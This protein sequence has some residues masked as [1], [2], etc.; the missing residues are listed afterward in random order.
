MRQQGQ[1]I[2]GFH[3]FTLFDAHPTKTPPRVLVHASTYKGKPLWGY[4][5]FDNHA[6]H[7][8]SCSRQGGCRSAH[9]RR[10]AVS[11]T[12]IKKR[13]EDVNK[14]CARIAIADKRWWTTPRNVRTIKHINIVPCR[15]ELVC[16]CC[17]CVLACLLC[18]LCFACFFS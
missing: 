3:C 18:L 2:V 4:P 12:R 11:Q 9:G 6:Q 13:M 7:I 17:V 5:I 10:D 14:A 8:A 16:W 1:A 15:A